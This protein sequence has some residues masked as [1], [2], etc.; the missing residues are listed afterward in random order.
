MDFGS[1]YV[2]KPDSNPPV[3]AYD[4]DSANKHTK[5]RT[6]S[7]LIRE[8]TSPYRRPEENLPG[9]GHYDGHLDKFGSK[10]THKMNFGSKYEFKPD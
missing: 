3:G 4:P 9:A 6:Q 2:F 8:E 5:A 10:V 7:C 1:K